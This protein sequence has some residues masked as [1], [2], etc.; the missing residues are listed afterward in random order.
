MT[1]AEQIEKLKEQLAEA[2]KSLDV[3]NENTKCWI[4]ADTQTRAYAIRLEKENEELKREQR[5]LRAEFDGYIAHHKLTHQII[6]DAQGLSPEDGKA[7]VANMNALK[8]QLAAMKLKSSEDFVEYEELQSER[9]EMLKFLYMARKAL[10]E[11]SG[12][13]DYFE[14]TH[15][16]VPGSDAYAL[17]GRAMEVYRAQRKAYEKL[18]G[19][20]EY[21]T[22]QKTELVEV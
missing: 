22:I 13:L 8:D 19:L 15:V 11:G 17:Q 3:R 12:L 7:L 1:D 6:S 20:P 21:V 9:D 4:Q 5:L 10:G 18:N 16:F 2:R 14:P